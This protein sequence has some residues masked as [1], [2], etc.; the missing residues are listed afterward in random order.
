MKIIKHGK[1][2]TIG[3]YKCSC[4]CVFELDKATNDIRIYGTYDTYD[5]WK[6]VCP[7]C[8]SSLCIEKIKEKE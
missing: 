3:R 4:G 2:T 6:P 1:H 8:G 7:E 5:K